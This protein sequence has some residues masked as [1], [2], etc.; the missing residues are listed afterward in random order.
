M[1]DGVK[2]AVVT[3]SNKGIG[4]AV[5][6]RLCRQYEGRV[7]LTSRD[8]QR[9]KDAVQKLETEGLRPKFHQLDI[10]S[11]ESVSSLKKFMLDTYGGVDILINNAGIAYKKAS[12]APPLEQVTVTVATNFTGTLNMMQAFV[13]IIKPHGRIV[14]MSSSAGSLS[15]LSNQK[16]RD[17]FSSTL[18][19]LEELVSMMDQLIVDVKDGKHEE[20]GWS[21]NFYSNSKVGMTALTKVFARDMTKSGE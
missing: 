4:L 12:T 20:N 8:T 9:G 19:T 11:E 13:P 2:V 21:E 18:L 6:R 1:A 10:N 3:G 16:L 17:K 14:N 15:R 7:Y 5:V